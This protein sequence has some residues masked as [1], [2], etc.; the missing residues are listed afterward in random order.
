MVERLLTDQ[1]VNFESNLL[2]QL[3]MLLGTEKLHSTTYH[4]PGHGIIERPNKTIKPNLA[5]YVNDKHDNWDE[6]LQLSISAYN[7][8]YH[9]TIKMTPYEAAFGRKP[10]MVA[11][12]IMNNRLPSSTRAQDVAEFT[13]ALREKADHLNRVIMYN[14]RHA[15]EQQKE[16]Y[17]RFAKY[18]A[19]FK[20]GDT[21]KINNCRRKVTLSKAFEPKFVGPYT[22][23]K[24]LNDLNYLLEAPGLKSEIVHYNRLYKYAMRPESL[25]Q[26]SSI[27]SFSSE[28]ETQFEQESNNQTF[29]EVDFS[30]PKRKRTTIITEHISDSNDNDLT[31]LFQDAREDSDDDRIECQVCHCL[32][33]PNGI[34]IHHTRMHKDLPFESADNE[35]DQTERVDQ[36]EGNDQVEQDDHIEQVDQIER[37]EVACLI[38]GRNFKRNGLA[39]H[40]GKKHRG[41]P[42]QA[43]ND[44]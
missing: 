13:K 34:K 39:I 5:K 3:C 9:K 11:D 29:I 19:E 26:S 27:E 38:C 40:Y 37:D 18:R 23:V 28:Q 15:Q 4:A 14:T 24:K 25:K 32:F 10:V 20:V 2:K 43:V 44:Q 1:G 17:D 33:K 8:T 16:Y 6:F 41:R 7:N 35:N 21:V 30:K 12:V 22:I 42:M 31:A 36:I